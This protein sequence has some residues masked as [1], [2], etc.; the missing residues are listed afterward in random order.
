MLLGWWELGMGVLGILLLQ[1][2]HKTPWFPFPGLSVGIIPLPGFPLELGSCHRTLSA[3]FWA[4]P[5]MV[6][7]CHMGFS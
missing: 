5:C 1:E 3:E 7:G 6:W 2:P 4:L